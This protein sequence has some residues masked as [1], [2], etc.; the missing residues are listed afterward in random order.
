MELYEVMKCQYRR[1]TSE[2]RICWPTSVLV[3]RLDR[4]RASCWMFDDV[5]VM[6]GRS[7]GRGALVDRLVA[8]K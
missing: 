1:K 5:S 4:T 6:R 2:R 7:G 8:T 3:S